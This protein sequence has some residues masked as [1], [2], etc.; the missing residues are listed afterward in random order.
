MEGSPWIFDDKIMVLKQWF[1]NFHPARNLIDI[2]SIWVW[3]PGIPIK[4]WDKDLPF[5]I[6]SKVGK[7]LKVDDHCLNQERGIYT[8]VCVEIDL[9][10]PLALGINIGDKEGLDSF[11]SRLMSIKTIQNLFWLWKGSPPIS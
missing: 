5:Y 8:R 6:A 10:Q 7:P 3:L 1:P 11:F 4:Y 2:V 9:S